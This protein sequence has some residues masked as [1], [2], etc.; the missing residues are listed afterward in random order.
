MLIV[1]AVLAVAMIAIGS[2]IIVRMLAFPIAQ[3]YTGLVLGGAMIALGL[4]RLRQIIAV[5]RAR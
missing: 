4:F 2:G 5:S 1:R 3:T